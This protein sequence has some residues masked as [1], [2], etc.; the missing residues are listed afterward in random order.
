MCAQCSQ[1]KM[2][3]RKYDEREE[4]AT[5]CPNCASNFCRKFYFDQHIPS[6]SDIVLRWAA[7]VIL[8]E[9]EVSRYWGN[10]MPANNLREWMYETIK[11]FRNHSTGLGKYVSH[12]GTTRMGFKAAANAMY[13]G[14][15]KQITVDRHQV[16]GPDGKTTDY[17]QFSFDHGNRM[18]SDYMRM[19]FTAGGIIH[20]TG[21]DDPGPREELLGD[22]IE[23][24][25]GILRVALMY[26]GCGVYLFGWGSVVEILTG[27]ERSLL[28]FNASAYPSGLKNRKI[29]SSNKKNKRSYTNEDCL[30]VPADG[31]R[32]VKCPIVINDVAEQE[33]V[34]MVDATEVDKAA[35]GTGF[36]AAAPSTEGAPNDSF[37]ASGEEASKRRRLTPQ[38]QFQGLFENAMSSITQIITSN[39]VCANCFSTTRKIEDCPNSNEASTWISMLVS[40]RDGME[41]RNSTI[42]TKAHDISISSTRDPIQ[43]SQMEESK[44]ETTQAQEQQSESKSGVI[45]FHKETKPLQE[46][47]G[48]WDIWSSKAGGKDPTKMGFRT[49]DELFDILHQP[50]IDSGYFPQRKHEPR[51]DQQKMSKYVNWTEEMAYGEQNH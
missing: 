13:Q 47:V 51:L 1:D 6:R 4:H 46:I 43:D 9:K 35:E 36:S 28:V 12:F 27:L 26:E 45:S 30:I 18:Y 32:M 31:V 39:D 48:E 17:Y 8:K 49:Q 2:S 14:Q 3:G 16:V 44:D 22:C 15:G 7:A 20:I 37:V 5:H 41:A 24:C 38:D 11:V 40:V 42:D 19:M 23:I 33:D 10:L 25:L 34:E 21:H 29:G 50:I